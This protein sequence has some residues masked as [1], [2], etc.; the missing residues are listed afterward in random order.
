MQ[1]NSEAVQIF[2]V[3]PYS[4]GF[5][6]VKDRLSND[7]R[8]QIIECDTP[9]QIIA[10]APQ[11]QGLVILVSA[12][13]TK[14]IV[15]PLTILRALAARVKSKQVKMILVTGVR[16][17][18]LRAKF[19]AAGVAEILSESVPAKSILFKL[20]KTAKLLI[21]NTQ[22][23]S[24]PSRIAP[25]N[26]APSNHA[27]L[28]PVTSSESKVDW[29]P[30][31]EFKEDFWL[32]SGS[33]PKRI[34][35]RWMMRI[36]GPSLVEG[37]W[38]EIELGG[39]VHEAWQWLPTARA[40]GIFATSGGTWIFK[41]QEPRIQ[42]EAWIFVGKAPELTYY[43]I[44]DEKE[45]PVPEFYRVKTRDSSAT[46]IEVVKDRPDSSF[47]SASINESWRKYGG[48]KIE[49]AEPAE[50]GGEIEKKLKDSSDA[51]SGVKF[52]NPLALLSDFWMTDSKKP[53][54][55]KG[56][57]QVTLIGP[58]PTVGHWEEI[59]LGGR[60]AWKWIPQG[61]EASTTYLKDA[62]TWVFLGDK[63]PEFNEGVWNFTGVTP[64]FSFFL[65]NDISE[66][67][68][69]N[70]LAT[71]FSSESKSFMTMAQDSEQ[72]L[73]RMDAIHESIQDAELVLRKRKSKDDPDYW[74]KEKKS[75]L[76]TA[77]EAKENTQEFNKKFA[78]PRSDATATKDAVA[79]ASAL[80]FKIGKPDA[81]TLSTL[82]VAFLTSELMCKK[83][84]TAEKIAQRFCTYLSVATGGLK[85]E[86]WNPSGEKPYAAANGNRP[87]LE[88]NDPAVLE[89]KVTY[90]I[91]RVAHAKGSS[92][93]VIDPAGFFA[94]ALR[95]SK[96][97]FASF[98]V[99]A[100]ANS[101]QS[102]RAAS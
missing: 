41:G 84:L 21:K 89:F 18:G 65:N 97:I 95:I 29:L 78:P 24:T 37:K 4:A 10:L 73:A 20:E 47:L 66:N 43:I 1:I 63:T 64:Q 6:M 61:S 39:S 71:K 28:A 92:E 102:L 54:N 74:Y 49:E 15:N 57:W 86:L 44:G 30:Q 67:R 13:H 3:K 77:T 69:G 9:A 11:S 5:E 100:S 90:G 33:I 25:K 55:K 87:E 81:P 19:I 31:K 16:D 98:E 68:L 94:A 38:S 2:L 53:I 27:I 59:V 72:A 76:L 101:E 88:M 8:Y 35:G 75:K 93:Q 50:V 99:E 56:M 79:L 22:L 26:T 80:P 34:G 51:S 82:A 85:V 91:L 42:G 12:P 17:E 32:F 45:V 70:P 7:S 23:P 40:T 62:G 58:S 14:D 96:G 60:T 46:L 83:G 52:V 48:Q 36:Q